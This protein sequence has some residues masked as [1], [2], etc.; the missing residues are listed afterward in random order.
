[1]ASILA[2]GAAKW[3]NFLLRILQFCAS[4]IILGVFAY[5]LATLADHDLHIEPWHIAV[6]AISGAAMVYSGIAIPCSLFWGGKSF[7]AGI[8]M[9]L[10]FIF[11]AGMVAIAI[12]DRGGTQSC[13]GDVD[14]PLGTGN[15]DTGAAGF[16]DGGFGVGDGQKFTYMVDLKLACRLQ[17]ATFAVSI[18]G[19]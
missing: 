11:G 5:F 12:M 16:G 3:A 17:K 1:M 18:I 10:D 19:M 6:T 4:A 14:T 2:A 9:G 8:G 13:S 7:F 15:A